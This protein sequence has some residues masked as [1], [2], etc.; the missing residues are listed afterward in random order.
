MTIGDEFLK[1]EQFE[2]QTQRHSFIKGEPVEERQAWLRHA[3][4]ICQASR[5]Q[6]SVREGVNDKGHPCYVI[7]FPDRMS[8]IAF[9]LNMFGDL[10][11]EHT[12]THS[13]EGVSP[14]YKRAFFLAA[15]ASLGIFGIGHYWQE[16]GDSVEFSFDRLSDQLVLEMLIHN[17]TIETAARGYE[18][19]LLFRKM[20]GL[21]PVGPL[22]APG[23]NL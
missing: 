11:G 21:D 10:E 5:I 7:G 1:A 6:Y 14:S 3:E 2:K 16:K 15:E 18:Q 22:G 12:Y 13:L 20:H 19:M 17:G 23:M 9:Q 4:A 8:H